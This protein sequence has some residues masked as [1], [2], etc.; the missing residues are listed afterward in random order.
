MHARVL[1][2]G[3]FDQLHPGHRFFLESAKSHGS[4]LIVALARDQHV[5]RFKN[6][7]PKQ[8]QE[9][10]M[11]IVAS[12]PFVDEVMLSD[13][14]PGTFQVIDL[15]QPDLLILGHDQDA[16]HHE[17]THWLLAHQREIP[18]IRLRKLSPA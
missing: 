1:V 10:R 12:L 6:K 11:S 9:E 7:L 8:T 5:Q 17:L 2:F 13:I 16:L 18:V 4:K 14:E 15:V 3:T